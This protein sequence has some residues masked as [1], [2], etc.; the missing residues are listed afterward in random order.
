MDKYDLDK[1]YEKA[2][3]FTRYLITALTMII[4]GIIGI[5]CS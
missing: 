2:L 3:W 5:C 4:L 1:D